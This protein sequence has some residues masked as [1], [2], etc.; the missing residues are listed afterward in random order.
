MS[1]PAH[2]MPRLKAIHPD[3]ADQDA[4]RLLDVVQDE[5]GTVPNLFR[6]M[7]NA[8]AVLEAYLGLGE[9]LSRGALPSAL[10]QQ[11]ALTVS[12]LNGCGYCIAAQCTLGRAIGLTEEAIADSRR[13]SCPD[14]R[15]SAALQLACSIVEK[16]GRVSDD[17]LRTARRAGFGDQEI[18]EI[19]AHVVHA[20]FSNYFNLVA[21]TEVDFPEVPPLAVTFDQPE[22]F[23]QTR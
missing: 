10:G 7:A 15:T 12:E 13:A 9:S 18:A 6:T 3:D 1:K 8:P 2:E 5:L 21:H 23:N 4:R 22:N 20:I 17:D 11:I 14:S 19:V 16:R